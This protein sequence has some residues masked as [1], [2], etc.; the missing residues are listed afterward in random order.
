[1]PPATLNHTLVTNFLIVNETDIKLKVY[2]NGTEI[3]WM[4][5]DI[6]TNKLIIPKISN[7]Y[8]G[9]HS[10]EIEATDYCQTIKSPP[11]SF[12]LNPNLSPVLVNSIPFV[13]FSMG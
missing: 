10:L 1:M 8:N 11:F 5:Y 6:A 12:T 4:E 2:S 9:T 13:S 3:S 7:D